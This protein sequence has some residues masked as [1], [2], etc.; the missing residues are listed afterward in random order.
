[1]KVKQSDFDIDGQKLKVRITEWKNGESE[2]FFDLSSKNKPADEKMEQDDK[3][4]D[5]R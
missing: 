4:Q 5:K 2:W 1:M 3:S